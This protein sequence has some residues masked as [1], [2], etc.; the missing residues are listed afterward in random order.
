M[1]ANIKFV[2][3]KFNVFNRQIFANELPMLPIRIGHART[4]LGG[5]ACNKKT[6]LFGKTQYY[7]FRMI[8]SDSIDLPQEE[9]EDII[10]HEMIH[11]FIAYK[12][13]QDT[14][15]HGK[16]FMKMMNDINK[17]FGRHISVSR[18][19]T[20]S[21][22]DTTYTLPP[23][24]RYICIT[25]LADGRTGI[26]IAPKTRIFQLWKTMPQLFKTKSCRWFYTTSPYFGR[27]P[28][29]LKPKIYVVEKEELQKH[30]QGA[31]P[32]KNDGHTISAES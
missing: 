7:N 10:I 1:K 13:I 5:L 17:R 24:P 16:L 19:Q 30:L 22:L 32:L 15:A 2:T 8:I 21:E 26:T 25:E 12:Q 9:L 27:Y 29:C 23:K 31:V 4:S 11:Y 18:R 3:E 14:S 28:T 6:N 20:A